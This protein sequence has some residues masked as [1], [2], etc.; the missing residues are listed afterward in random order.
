MIIDINDRKKNELSLKHVSEHN[1]LTDALNLRSLE[2]MIL[3][4]QIE[5]K[6]KQAAMV[7]IYVRRYNHIVTT[8]GYKNW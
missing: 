8:Y 2:K 6:I 1:A 5:G 4:Q 3:N 7:M